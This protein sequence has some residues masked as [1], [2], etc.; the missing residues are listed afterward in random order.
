MGGNATAIMKDGTQTNAEKIPL[1][2]IGRTNFCKEVYKLLKSLNNEFIKKFKEPIWETIDYNL[3]NG[4]ASFIMDPSVDEVELLKYKKMAGDIDVIVPDYLKVK[5]WDFLNELENKKI[6]ENI[7]YMGSNKPTIQS[8]GDQINA[9]FLVQFDDF[10]IACQV[11]FEFLPF[12]NNQ[13]TEWARFSH[14]SSFD[15]AKQ[16]IKAVHH[17]YLIRAIVGSSSLRRDVLIATNKSTFN[18]IKISKSKNSLNPKMLKFS[19]S[20]GLRVAYEPLIDN[21]GKIIKIDGKEVYKEIPTSQ[22][23]YITSIQEI[24]KIC[25]KDV[26]SKDIKKFYSFVGLVEL[27]KKYLTKEQIQNA[28]KRYEELLWS[29]IPRA[30]E[31]EKQNPSLDFEIKSKGYYYLIN[32]LNLDEINKSKIDEYYKEYGTKRISK[33]FIDFF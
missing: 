17:K 3:F 30:Q 29:V 16:Y 13:P 28:V 8:I 11:D 20:K 32:H 2:K 25:F 19:V 4:S 18:N 12:E 27:M 33:S 6:T 22:S 7:R 1:E 24:F 21:E 14:S 10:K 15:D 26:E 5:L 23:D 9:I 31:L